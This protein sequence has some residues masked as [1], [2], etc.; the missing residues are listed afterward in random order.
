MISQRRIDGFVG[1]DHEYIAYLESKYLELKAQ[2][3]IAHPGPPSPPPSFDGDNDFKIFRYEPCSSTQGSSQ[4]PRPAKKQRTQ[5]RWQDR[6]EEEMD[7]MLRDINNEDLALR[8]KRVG[9]SLSSDILM[10][11]D[12]IVDGKTPRTERVTS[13]TNISVVCYNPSNA[14][15][16]LLDSFAVG[17]AALGIETAFL[18]QVYHFRILVLVSS[19]C[20]ALDRGV[21]MIVVEDIMRKCVSESTAKNLSRLRGGA[22]W[23]NRMMSALAAVL[24]H[25]AYELFILCEW[26]IR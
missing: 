12:L 11:L 20:V 6:L 21:P 8:R 9:L 19:C 25:L 10:A 3:S 13:D 22:L 26:K 7:A 17:T 5:E 2:S 16:Q 14:I 23:V 15:V 4:P 1:T 24:G 18:A